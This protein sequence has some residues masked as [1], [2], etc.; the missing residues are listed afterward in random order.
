RFLHLSWQDYLLARHAITEKR[1]LNPGTISH[2]SAMPYYIGLTGDA[3]LLL[4]LAE[5][6]RFEPLAASLPEMP[7]VSLDLV[8]NLLAPLLENIMPLDTVRAYAIKTIASFAPRTSAASRFGYLSDLVL[9]SAP[10]DLAYY[11][12][13]LIHYNTEHYRLAA[14]SFSEVLEQ[15]D[16]RPWLAAQAHVQ[17][18][19][20]FRLCNSQQLAA[21]HFQTALQLFSET[22][23]TDYYLALFEYALVIKAIN[24]ARAAWDIYKECHGFFSGDGRGSVRSK[25]DDRNAARCKIQLAEIHLH[26]WGRT[27]DDSPD[28][29][30]LG[31]AERLYSFALPVLEEQHYLRGVAE[32]YLG[33]SCISERMGDFE[34]SEELAHL[35]LNV[36]QQ[37]YF[38]RRAAYCHVQLAKAQRAQGKLDHAIH[39]LMVADSIW[40]QIDNYLGAARTQHELSTTYRLMGLEEQAIEAGKSSRSLFMAYDIRAH[41]GLWEPV[42]N[43][44][45]LSADARPEQM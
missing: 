38:P 20:S 4:D 1:A 23:G 12:L 42:D 14:A 18:G 6:E 33:L 35:A 7:A 37:V 21:D 36:S 11:R 24:G 40:Q 39:H 25:D 30:H 32:C 10:P 43:T 17:L 44:E 26:N 2:E 16:V 45:F 27:K 31:E 22:R 19:R 3:S 28:L 5:Q 15:E 41:D 34:E 9:E 8:R 13:G 29:Q